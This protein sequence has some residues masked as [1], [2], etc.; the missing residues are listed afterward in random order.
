MA[1]AEGD[2]LAAGN[3]S[4]IE[5]VVA[6]SVSSRAGARDI[7]RNYGTVDFGRESL[8]QSGG[9]CFSLYD[10]I[11]HDLMLERAIQL[12]DVLEKS[13]RQLRSHARAG[14]SVPPTQET[15]PRKT[16]YTI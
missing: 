13:A 14:A 15:R 8:E 4:E 10:P 12:A 3:R 6:N 9:S 11:N 7:L 2:Q 1:E 16:R 5:I